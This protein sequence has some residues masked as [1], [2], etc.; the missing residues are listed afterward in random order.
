[1]FSRAQAESWLV[2]VST[3]AGV[4]EGRVFRHGPSAAII[5]T[6]SVEYAD[7]TEIVRRSTRGSGTI[8]GAVAGGL[9][10]GAFAFALASGLCDSSS[11]GTDFV[12][13]V[14]AGVLPGALL[15]M[16]IGKLVRPGEMLWID[17]WRREPRASFER[18]N[19]APL[20]TRHSHACHIKWPR[21]IV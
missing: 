3:P 19:E 9:V 10:L 5:D 18:S 20:E 13:V 1:V 4:I 11:C 2:R 12:A 21:Y 14:A 16:V 7:V 17:V 8:P 15:G 6:T